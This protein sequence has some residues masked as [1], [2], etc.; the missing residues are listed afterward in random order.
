MWGEIYEKATSTITSGEYIIVCEEQN[1]LFNGN[2]TT[3]D[4][5]NN[6]VSVTINDDKI[7]TNSQYSFTID[8]AENTIKS[9][10]GYYIG[11]TT[12][13]NGLQS[14]TSTKYTNNISSADII[15]SGGAHLRYN[16]ASNQLRF[17][18]F[19]SSTYTAQK[20]IQLYKLIEEECD[21][22]S[23]TLTTPVHGTASLSKTKVC[24]NDEIEVAYMPDAGYMLDKILA[25]DVE[26][27]N[28]ITITEATTIQVLFKEI[29]PEPSVDI[30]EWNPD[31]IK[32]DIDNYDAVSAI[33]QNQNTQSGHKEN[34]ATG[35]FFSKYFEASGENKMLAIYNGTKD[36]IKLDDYRIVRSNKG[37]TGVNFQSYDLDTL[38]RIKKGYIC[39]NEEIIL[40]HFNSGS[41]SAD[42][43]AAKQ[44][45]YDKWYTTTANT[46]M[47]NVLNFSGPMSIGLYKKSTSKYI[48]VIGASTNSSGTGD[49]IQINASNSVAC[50]AATNST[51]ND[52]A[53]F[54]TLYGDSINGTS[55]D[56]FLST[57]RCLLIRKNTV[58]SGDS[59]VKYNVYTT[60]LD[61]SSDVAAAFVTLSSEWVGYQV[62][63]KSSEE[64]RLTCEG[65][66]YVGGYDYNNYYAQYE[67]LDTI[68]LES[69]IYDS[70]TG[71][72]TISIPELDTLSC[73][74][75]KVIVSDGESTLEKAYQIPIFVQ[76]NIYTTDITF[77]KEGPDC[78]TCDVVVLNNKTLTVAGTASKNRDV[79]LYQGAKLIVPTSTTYT[80]NSLALRRDNNTIS[81]LGYQGTLTLNHLYFDL[82]IDYKDWY[83]VALPDTFTLSKLRFANGK[84]AIHRTDYWVK[85]YDG[86]HRAETQAGSW[87]TAPNDTLFQPGA[88]FI[89]GLADELKKKELRFEFNASQTLTNEK[90]PA[91]GYK[92]AGNL[93]AWGIN[94][95]VRPNHK[96]WNLVGNPYMNIYDTDFAKAIRAGYLYKDERTG[97]WN[98]QWL[99]SDT[100]S[101][102]LRY[103]VIPNKAS[104]FADAGY[105]ESVALDDRPLLP[106]TCFFVQMGGTNDNAQS[107]RFNISKK[108]N[109]IVARSYQEEEDDELFLRIKVNDWKTGCF[110]SNQFTDEYEPGDDL[111]SRYPIYQTINGFK[112]LYSAVNDSIIENGIQVA[113]PSGTL[114]LDPKVDVSLFDEINVLYNEQWYSLLY[115]ETVNIESGS[116]ILQAKRKNKNVSTDI[117]NVTPTNGLYKF[118][119]GKC[120]YINKNGYIYNTLG[121]KLK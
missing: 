21:S 36:T 27:E 39:P 47:G 77:T 65:M 100:T 121:T 82:Y 102:K 115:G 40:A 14:S 34:V 1:V 19:K 24:P 96:G 46:G 9:H 31:Y 15:S 55:H 64:H 116:F 108:R 58:H 119:D 90:N 67:S 62:G 18:Y 118:T 3:L 13:A 4:A 68:P 43:C 23:I 95:S 45:N 69:G 106:F 26:V 75:L 114:Y 72:Y 89:I 6:Y 41:N 99:L 42:T 113:S 59:A 73:T 83:Y 117:E 88:G 8:I 79:K 30:V 70:E 101:S 22:V 85:W 66:A 57:N 93:C 44:D 112:L 80:I 51:Y 56:Y 35:L 5:T 104:Q 33:I 63:K 103:A 105:Y 61:C 81:T 84:N 111:E 78:A 17:R 48:D 52:G 10:S 20:A 11:Q 97:S 49:L 120:I 86:K 32:V 37:S 25:N 98:G 53:G 54:S 60:Q 16:S 94:S 29:P 76:D 109:N 12:N 110:I 50:A 28:L 107:L 38:G 74:N 7:E 92:A 71:T 87:A 91:N 2:L